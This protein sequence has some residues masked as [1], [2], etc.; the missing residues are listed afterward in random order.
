MY[1]GVD[2]YP[3]HQGDPSTL[4]FGPRAGIAWSLDSKTVV[5]GG[6]GLF[7]APPQIAQAFDQGALGTRGFTATTTY[8]ASTDGGLSPCSG[9]SLTNPFPNGIA[10]PQGAAE[11]L[12]TG[13]GGEVDFIDSVVAIRIRASVFDRRE[14]GADGPACRCRSATSAAAASVSP[15]AAPSTPG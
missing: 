10:S 11:G 5:R 9:C 15:W 13:V 1:A 6:Y 8:T 3:E 12:L 4:N 7:W 2:G 14:A